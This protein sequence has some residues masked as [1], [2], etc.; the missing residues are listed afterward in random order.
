MPSMSATAQVM[1]FDMAGIAV[2]QG[3]ACS[4][5]KVSPSHVLQAMGEN[6]DNAKCA[7]RVSLGRTTTSAEIDRFVDVWA[8]MARRRQSETGA[9]RSVG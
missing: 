4:S 6:A 7:I 5:G 9:Q 1:R 3:S 8:E 2:S